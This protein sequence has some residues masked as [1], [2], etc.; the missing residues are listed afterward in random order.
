MAL[1]GA[2]PRHGKTGVE[3]PRE[4]VCDRVAGMMEIAP[5]TQFGFGTSMS[6]DPA[7][8]WLERFREIG[9]LIETH[10]DTLVERWSE[11][12]LIEQPTADDVFRAELRDSL[13]EW[14]RALGRALAKSSPA[15]ASDHRVLALEHGEQRW[16]VGWK[17]G[18]VVRDYQMLRLVILDFL[19][20]TLPQPLQTRECMAVGLGIDEAIGAS[21]AAYV[22]HRDQAMH[23][24]HQRMNEFLS[25][26][27]HELR[28]FL[29][30]LTSA[31]DVQELQQP[32]LAGSEM[33]GIIRRSTEHL[34]RL[35]GDLLDVS[36]AAA[37][38]LVIERGPVDLLE[39]AQR[40]V[41]ITRATITERGQ[42]L[43]VDLPNTPL[44]ISGDAFRLTQVLVNLLHNA[45]KYSP[46]GRSI[47]LQLREEG[48]EAVARVR[49][50]GI[51]IAP[52]TLPEI[53]KLFVQA[54]SGPARS[55]GGLGIGLALVSKL[56]EL[57]GGN[58]SAFSAGAGQ[59]S[60]FVVR[61]PIATNSATSEATG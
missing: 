61:L 44:V 59:G 1:G 31:L 10:A 18:E 26:L 34:T 21:I 47:Y 42:R 22:R 2:A 11:R 29:A 43:H 20:A 54:E 32:D 40:A 41:E 39:I 35:V 45:C 23:T 12:A 30:P 51:G 5:I 52:E 33:H 49:D 58:V 8:L 6:I 48:K 14:L 3:R 50:E 36:R 37:G 16:H 38:K 28:N 55:S 17:L 9:A 4:L 46:Q 53:F 27:S 60:E 57:H 25:V 15:A 56:V 13:P 7:Q 19:D 24:A